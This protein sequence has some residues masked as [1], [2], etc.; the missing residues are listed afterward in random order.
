[1]GRP[2]ETSD[3]ELLSSVRSHS[4]A[5]TSEI[6]DE[7]GMTRQGTQKRLD[8]LHEQG[9]VNRKDIGTVVVWYIDCE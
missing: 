7:V 9:K 8:E 5:G 2:R 1:M 4:P 6:A 3:E